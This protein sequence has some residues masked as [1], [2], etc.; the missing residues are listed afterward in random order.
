[1]LADKLPPN[2]RETANC[3]SALMF[4]FALPILFKGRKTTLGPNDLYDVLSE[5]KAEK[6]GEK[7]FEAWQDESKKK[8]LKG[9]NPKNGMLR[10]I[11][12][13]FGWELIATGFVIGGLELGLRRV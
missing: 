1:M 2:P 7:L 8:D 3:I 12:K 10:V 9:G 13:V 6:L 5:H 11:L 4:C